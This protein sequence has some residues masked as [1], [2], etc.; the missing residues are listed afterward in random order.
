LIKERTFFT[1]SPQ[2]KTCTSEAGSHELSILLI[3]DN[4][5]DVFLVEEAIKAEDLSYC[6]THAAD[7]ERAILLLRQLEDDE[8]LPCPALVLLDLNLPRK[9]GD[10]VLERL[11]ASERCKNIP[12]IVL[13]SSDS[14]SDREKAQRLGANA[15]FRKP[16]DLDEFLK[17]GAVVKKI[18]ADTPK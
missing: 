11:R 2:W 5:A 13:T 17:L 4:P 1:T 8:S 10:E 7:G 18:L 16:S 3:E 9:S 14:A 12:V 6:L 15:Y